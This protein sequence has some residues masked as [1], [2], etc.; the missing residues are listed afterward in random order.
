MILPDTT[1]LVYAYNE[2]APVHSA[3]RAW[4]EEL[5]S[6]AEPVA[7]T[8]ATVGGF[9]RVCTSRAVMEKPLR[10]SS[11]LEIVDQWLAQSSIRLIR[12]GEQHWPILKRLLAAIN[13]GGNLITDAHLAALAIEHDCEIY[14]TDTDFARFAGLRWRNPLQR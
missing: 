14:S 11:A 9:L 7:L 3:A 4:I 6:G 5:F 8:W 10:V 1:L 2:D 12:P 13:L